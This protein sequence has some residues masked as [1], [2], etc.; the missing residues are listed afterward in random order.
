MR[1]FNALIKTQRKENK[2]KEN[3]YKSL[4][5]KESGTLPARFGK[6]IYIRKEHHERISQIVHVIGDSE[7]TIAGYIDNVLNHHFQSFEQ[8]ITQSFSDKVFFK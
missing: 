3:E 8:E 6:S 2:E 4:F 7:I 1:I 5:I